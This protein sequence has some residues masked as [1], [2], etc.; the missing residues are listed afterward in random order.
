MLMRFARLHP[1]FSHGFSTHFPFEKRD[2]HW[3][4]KCHFDGA[5]IFCHGSC[6]KMWRKTILHIWGQCI[7]SCNECTCIINIP[8]TMTPQIWPPPINEHSLKKERRPGNFISH[9]ARRIRR[10]RCTVNHLV[11]W[12]KTGTSWMWHWFQAPYYVPMCVAPCRSDFQIP[13]IPFFSHKCSRVMNAPLKMNAKN[14][15][16]SAFLLRAYMVLYIP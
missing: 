12:Y 8:P 4:E 11:H 7:Y 2:Q 6:T 5:K 1:W 3:K 10:A 16:R 15:K 14:R 13:S 9:S